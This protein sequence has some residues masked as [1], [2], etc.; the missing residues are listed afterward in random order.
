VDAQ[1]GV[2]EGI[3]GSLDG[4]RVYKRKIKGVAVAYRWRGDRDRVGLVG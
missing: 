3:S 2:L 4:K 1:C